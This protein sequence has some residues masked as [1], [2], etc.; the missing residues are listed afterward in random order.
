MSQLFLIVLQGS[1]NASTSVM[2]KKALGIPRAFHI[3]QKLFIP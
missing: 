2:V 3:E 1:E